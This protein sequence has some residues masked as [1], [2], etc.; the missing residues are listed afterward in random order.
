[1]TCKVCTGISPPT[2]PCGIGARVYVDEDG[3][4]VG[5]IPG[6]PYT[7]QGPCS[8]LSLE[9]MRKPATL[10]GVTSED[11]ENL[12]SSRHRKNYHLNFDALEALAEWIPI[13]RD[14]V[15]FAYKG[16]CDRDK[17]SYDGA[18]LFLKLIERP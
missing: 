13:I 5:K 16:R 7:E 14:S 1:M 8:F 18:I 10:K 17:R 6:C 11:Y 4:I 3:I 9:H 15:S 12:W 2:L